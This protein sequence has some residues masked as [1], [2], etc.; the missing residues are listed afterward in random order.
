MNTLLLALAILSLALLLWQWG[1]AWRFPLHRRRQADGFAPAL[2]LLKPLKGCDAETEACLRSWL[3]QEYAGPVQVLFLVAADDDPAVALVRQLIAEHPQRTAELV[4]CPE[5]LG[6]NSKVSKLAQ[7]AP[8]ARHGVLVV[9]DADVHVPPGFLGELVAPLRDERVVLVSPFYE[10]A[11]PTT[12]AMHWEAVAVNA[13]FWSSV[14]QARRL[15]GMRFAL[16]AVMAVRRE[17]L[18]Q[19][20]GFGALV[21][22]LADDYELGH[23][24]TAASH[25]PHRCYPN[26]VP[27]GTKFG[28]RR[29]MAGEQVRKEREALREPTLTP[30]LSRRTGE[31]ARRAGEGTPGTARPTIALCPT[32]VACRE[33]P[34]GWGAVWRH[35][36]RW[37]RTIRHCQPL[38]YAFS[39]LSNPTLWVLSWAATTRHAAAWVGVGLCLA[40]RLAMAAHC[41]WRLT[42]SWRHLPWLWLAPVKDLLQA[43][44]WVM[45]FVGR[46][47][48]WRGER[49][50]VL[51]G[52]TLS[53]CTGFDR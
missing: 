26:S 10:M 24:L 52:G 30:A 17:A 36:L 39:L 43:A 34:R 21:K 41:Q 32:V 23:R 50:R 25:E 51:P 4:V 29:F 6:P 19:A 33:A 2:S 44:L 14:L 5:R 28:S 22:H 11:T 40:C 53:P 7:A 35:Q 16:G 47:V 46:T 18:E 38:P 1:E 12:V 9:S 31:G 48:E 3:A 8:H 20:G 15:G 37:A 13:D 27:G 45:A 49:Y 42:R